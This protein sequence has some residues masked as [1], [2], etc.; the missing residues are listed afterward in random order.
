MAAPTNAAPSAQHAMVSMMNF[1]VFIGWLVL[2][3]CAISGDKK[4]FPHM[5]NKLNRKMQNY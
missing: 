1:I 5:C 2:V 3:L 4:T